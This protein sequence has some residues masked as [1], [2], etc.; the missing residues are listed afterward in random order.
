MKKILI[1]GASGFVGKNL[2][3]YFST[4]Y[5][6]YSPSHQELNLLD[7]E[8]VK[9]YILKNEIISVIHC[10]NVG[11]SRID[12][13]KKDII[14]TNLKMFFNIINNEK[15]L[16]R[17]I[18]FSSGAEYDKTRPIIKVREE[19][20]GVKIPIDD[21]GFY[22]YTCSK[23]LEALNSKK[24]ITLRLFGIYGKYENYLV[25]FISNSILRNI[26]H[27]SIIINQNVYFDYLYI[28]DLVYIVNYFL[29]N[30][31]RYNIYNVSSGKKIN[32]ITIAKIINSISNY[33]SKII[34]KNK[35]LNNEYTASNKRLQNEL[36]KFKFTTIREGVK[37]LF[38]WYI[39][40]I[41]NINKNNIINNRYIKLIKHK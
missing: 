25:R 3:E 33:Q 18:Y 8:K 32:L 24:I 10:A 21:Y 5:K 4:S 2:K 26:F 28:D 20:F 16:E 39:S 11:G 9:K 29:I 15:F 12:L 13:D 35:G 1:T 38:D 34:V 6:I 19:D 36:K 40:N 37:K 14:Y 17:I 7:T 27:Q 30:K 22:K 41:N 31:S 23:Y